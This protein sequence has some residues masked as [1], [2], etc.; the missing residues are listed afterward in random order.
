MKIIRVFPR[1]TKATPDDADVRIGTGPGLFDEADEVHISCAFTWDLPLAERLELAWRTVAKTRI[2]GPATGERGEAFTPGLYLRHGYTIT[3][4]GC[5]NRCWY[6]DVWK[7]EGT[8]RELPIQ[9][10]RNVLDDNLLACSPEHIKAVFSMLQ[11]QSGTREFTGGLES[12]RMTPAIAEGLRE[13]R[14][15]QVF[16]AFD[17]PEKYEPLARAVEMLL[18]A[19]FTKASKVIRTFVLIGYPG[20]TKERALA[21]LMAAQKAGAVPAAMLYRNREG[22]R[23]ESW[24]KFQRTFIRPSTT[25]G[26]MMNQEP[27]RWGSLQEA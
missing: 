14:P 10:G 5:P 6:C 13:L 15:K 2:G 8:T 16:F 1:R 25:A 20:D 27:R 21:R 3:S 9:P 4:R 11:Y 7:R 26:Y 22:K 12:A 17:S 19:G 18:A 23:D 24:A